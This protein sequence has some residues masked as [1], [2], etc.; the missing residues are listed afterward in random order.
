[1]YIYKVISRRGSVP[2]V[3]TFRLALNYEMRCRLSEFVVDVLNELTDLSSLTVNCHLTKTLAA[4]ICIRV[5]SS[6]VRPLQ[7]GEKHTYI[8]CIFNPSKV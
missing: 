3:T 1:M 8:Y 6:V 4:M 7:W 5:P 2:S